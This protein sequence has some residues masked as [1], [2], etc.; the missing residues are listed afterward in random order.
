MPPSAL[1]KAP[2]VSSQRGQRGDPR[3]ALPAGW[4][5]QGPDGAA[6]GATGGPGRV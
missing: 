3:P 1:Q 5:L 2:S 4:P 6:E